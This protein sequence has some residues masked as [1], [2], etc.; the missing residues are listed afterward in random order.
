MKKNPPAPSS[1]R[2]NQPFVATRLLAGLALAWPALANAA[3]A[4]DAQSVVIV[5]PKADAA[6]L[7]RIG[8]SDPVSLLLDQPGVSAYG[9]GGVSGLPALRGL[10]DDRIKIRVDGGEATAACGNHMNAPLSYVDPT[11][12]AS[13]SVTAGITPVSAGGDNIAGVIEIDTVQPLFAVTGQSL[14]AAGS[15]TVQGRTVDDSLTR[16]ATATLASD[17][18]SA[19]WAG[20]TT[21]AS[22]YKDG[23][24]RTVADTLYKSTNQSLTLGA[25]TPDQR[26]SLKIGQQRIPYQGFPNEFMDMTDNRAVHANLAWD[27]RLGWGALHAK[28]FWQNTEHEM[29]FFSSERAGTMPMNTHGRDASASLQADIPADGGTL[30][31][32]AEF[33]RHRLDDWWPAVAD[34]MMMGPQAYVNVDGG[35]RDRLGLF[36]EWDGKLA[37]RWSIDAGLRAESVHTGAGVVQDYGC[38]M[39]C[40]ADAAAAAAFNAS[41]RTRRDTNVDATLVGR[42]EAGPNASYEFGIARK[43]RSPSLYERYSWGRGTMAMTMIGWFGDANGYVGD[44]GLKPEVARTVS[45]TADWH[46]G[47]PSGGFLRVTPFFTAVRDFIDADVIGSYQPGDA[48]G[49]TRS[50]LQFANHDAHLYGVNVSWRVPVAASPSSG[51][52]SV[53]GKFDWTRGRRND[54]GDLYH[55][56]PPSLDVAVVQTLDRWSAQ[57]GLQAVARKSHVDVRRA[58]PAT[59]AYALVNLGARYEFRN[60][61]SLQAGV[62]NLF[63]RQYGQPL[64][65][66]NIAAFEAGGALSPVA[67]AGRSFDAGATWKF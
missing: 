67:G 38:G 23:N 53:E 58:E 26:W 14:L 66:V 8:A 39:M 47:G 11:L 15:L 12:V 42:F 9:N 27:A 5:A 13:T 28:A 49:P 2:S 32:G 65:G 37:D 41:D 20:A 10:A 48:D 35:R 33:H 18:L 19:T 56:M 36:G 62:R 29:G 50:L 44:I 45:A 3:D 1:R 55:I 34:S 54:G 60:G 6:V 4:A 25:R 64:G 46:D 59:P 21:A 22:S 43:T 52:T 63:D 40:A 30:K 51:Q 31:V 57:A 16:S 7:K 24:G 61:S 17:W